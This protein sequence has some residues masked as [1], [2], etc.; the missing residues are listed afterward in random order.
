MLEVQEKG[1]TDTN[2]IIQKGQLHKEND[3]EWLLTK[4]TRHGTPIPS[5]FF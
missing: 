4:A 2:V 1:I 3:L 5:S